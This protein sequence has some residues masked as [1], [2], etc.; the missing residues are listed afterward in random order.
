MSARKF[1]YAFR[2]SSLPIL[3]S[4]NTLNSSFS[5]NVVVDSFA[6]SSSR[7]TPIPRTGT[8]FS[9]IRH[10]EQD[11]YVEDRESIPGHVYA[12]EE[13]VD[14]G[15]EQRVD[16]LQDCVVNGVLDLQR[17]EGPLSSFYYGFG[18]TDEERNQALTLLAKD[19]LEWRPDLFK[20]LQKALR[21]VRSY[22]YEKRHGAHVWIPND[23]KG[24]KRQHTDFDDNLDENENRSGV[25][26][27]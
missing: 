21:D 24:R 1:S 19:R 3:R 20:A 23:H 16:S 26:C 6:N 10:E 17:A 15:N 14:H 13:F 25:D 8:S 18:R 7:T 2:A 12:R 4:P 5:T 27:T 22:K 9:R 11:P